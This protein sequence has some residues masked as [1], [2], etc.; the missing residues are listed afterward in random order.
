MA[1]LSEGTEQTPRQNECFEV[2]TPLKEQSRHNSFE[3]GKKTKRKQKDP[4]R[5]QNETSAKAT[6]TTWEEQSRRH[7]WK[8]RGLR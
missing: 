1:G 5:H 4:S 2:E 8:V 6:K 3:K 7:A